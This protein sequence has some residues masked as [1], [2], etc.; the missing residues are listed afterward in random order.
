MKN[1]TI[2]N[3][4]IFAVGGVVLAFLS[5]AGCN[6][7][8]STSSH[9]EN[10]AHEEQQPTNPTPPMRVMDTQLPEGADLDQVVEDALKSIEKGKATGD[11]SLVMNEGIMKLRAVNKTDSNHLGAIYH[12]GIFSIESGQ[13]KKGL[14]RFEKLVLLQPENQEYKDKLDEIRQKLN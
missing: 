10:H 3:L 1:S 5:L 8:T 2:S 14:K 4:I 12:L 7:D 11:M 6:S 13:L 9:N